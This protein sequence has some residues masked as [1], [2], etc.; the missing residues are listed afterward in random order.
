M[1]RLPSLVAILLFVVARLAGQT[2]LS[3]AA[4]ALSESTKAAQSAVATQWKASQISPARAEEL[5]RACRNLAALD[6][7]EHDQNC[8]TNPAVVWALGF[9]ER[10]TAKLSPRAK[11]SVRAYREIYSHDSSANLAPSGLAI[12][13]DKDVRAALV[14]AL[15]TDINDVSATYLAGADRG[16]TRRRIAAEASLNVLFADLKDALGVKSSLLPEDPLALAGPEAID[17]EISGLKAYKTKLDH[18]AAV[19]PTPDIRETLEP[20]RRRLNRLDQI[21][22]S[23]QVGQFHRARDEIEASLDTATWRRLA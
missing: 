7:S 16:D 18:A 19:F 2:H 13:A 17:K 14:A 5:I 11:E 4:G 10:P 1:R 8:R 12:P 9:L 3:P 15:V 6:S 21:V 22:V 20:V 23:D